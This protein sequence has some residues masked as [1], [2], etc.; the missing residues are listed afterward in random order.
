MPN[1]LPF[2]VKNITYMS[3]KT[4]L[5]ILACIS[6]VLGSVLLYAALPQQAIFDTTM[7]LFACI[8]IGSSIGLL[9]SDKSEA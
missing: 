6:F 1:A 7:L 8:I 5:N 2:T 9:L 4:A 3:N